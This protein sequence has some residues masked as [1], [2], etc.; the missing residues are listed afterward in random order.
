MVT[1]L[2][3]KIYWKEF[4]RGLCWELLFFKFFNDLPNG[5]ESIRK[6][7]ADD[8]SLFSKVKDPTFSELKFVSAIFYQI[9]IFSPNDS[10]SKTMKNVF[11][12]I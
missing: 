10:P 9:F 7:F 11:Y 1:F 12:F 5:I 4:Q 2:R 8:T 3:G 6:I